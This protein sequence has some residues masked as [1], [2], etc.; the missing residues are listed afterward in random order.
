MMLSLEAERSESSA[1][2]CPKRGL[3]G[4]LAYLLAGGEGSLLLRG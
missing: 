4:L 2:S 3:K 1:I